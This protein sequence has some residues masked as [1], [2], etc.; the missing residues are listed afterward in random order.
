M[1]APLSG[2]NS[3]PSEAQLSIAIIHWSSTPARHP[4]G[5]ALDLQ[6]RAR[7]WDMQRTLRLARRKWTSYRRARRHCAWWWQSNGLARDTRVAVQP[8]RV[9]DA[10]AVWCCLEPP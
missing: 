8:A 1:Y 7:S 2:E 10:S 6:P 4:N 9:V 5:R 3:S